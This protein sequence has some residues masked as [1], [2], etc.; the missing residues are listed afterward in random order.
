[1]I[2]MDTSIRRLYDEKRI[3]ARAAFDKAIEK[4]EFKDLLAAAPPPGAR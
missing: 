3:T 2:D 1:M 4:S